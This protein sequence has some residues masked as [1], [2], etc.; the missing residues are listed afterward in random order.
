MRDADC[1][2]TLVC[3]DYLPYQ[4]VFIQG[5]EWDVG[6]HYVGEMGSQTLNKTLT[7]QITDGQLEWS[8]LDD[9]FDV[10]SIGYGEEQR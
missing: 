8:A 4:I 5:Y 3:N 6:I 2:G 1:W 9:D 10:V 7:D